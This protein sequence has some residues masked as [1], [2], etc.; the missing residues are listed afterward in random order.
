M[1]TFYEERNFHIPKYVRIFDTTLRDGEQTPGVA[2]NVEQKLLIAKQLNKLGV[3][4]IEAGFP[5]ATRGE[6]EAVK[7]IK[8]QGLSSKICALARC[9]RNDIDAA[10]D[11]DVDIIHIFIPTSDIQVKY[12]IKKSR[13]E[14]L[15]IVYENVRYVKDHGFEC[16]FSAMDATRTDIDFLIKVFKT[17]EEAGA[18]YINIPDTV[19]IATPEKMFN[20]V[21]KVR[22]NVKIPIDVHCHNDLG[23]A[24]A[25]SI[26]SVLAGADGV[27][28]TVN[29]LGE[30]A[31]NASL[32]QVVIILKYV[33]NIETKVKTEYLYETSKLVERLTGIKLMPN[34][35]IV[36]ENAFSHESGIHTHGVIQKPETF[37]PGIIKPEM[38]GHRRR[39]VAGK[40]SGIHGLE[41]LIKEMGY[42]LSKEQIKIIVDRVKELGDK[43]K[44]ITEADLQAIVEDMI[45]G[46]KDKK[47]VE[48][49]ELAVMTGNKVIPTASVKIRF[50]DKT[51]I[52]SD[53]GVGPVDAAIKAIRRVIKEIEDIKLVEYRLE[54][55]SGGSDALASV[56]VILEDSRG[57]KSIGR[58]VREDIVM[59]SV[60]AMIQGINRIFILRERMDRND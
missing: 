31:G 48:L 28:V 47:Y 46:I 53:T 10:I 36:G 18:D 35:P 9:K 56:T 5:A 19:G 39:I 21:K 52:G 32:E 2:L 40:H 29:G 1:F 16:L 44:K 59:A 58:A 41:K 55:I 6:R 24:V 13:E 4:I 11:C 12:T 15:D 17:A 49:E 51:L 14:I 22:E 8:N 42:D 45:G 3:D 20:L 33:Y 54:A 27:Q 50:K 7:Y 34:Y 26:A 38:V 30:R 43:G 25:N 60:E 37:E 57:I 23:L